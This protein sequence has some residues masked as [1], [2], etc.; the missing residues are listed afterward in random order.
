MQRIC[1]FVPRSLDL[2]TDTCFRQLAVVRG[3]VS[4]RSQEIGRNVNAIE[5]RCAPVSYGIVV[6]QRYDQKR[7][8]R[9]TV[10]RDKRDKKRWAI[11]QIE[12]L[13]QKV[14]LIGVECVS[15][16]LTTDQGETVTDEGVERRVNAKLSSA[17]LRKSYRAQFVMSTREPEDLPQ[18]MAER[19][20]VR[21]ICLVHISLEKVDK[22]LR[23]HHWW[24]FGER[25]ELAHFRLRL[26][27]GHADLRIQM[28]SGGSLVNNEADRIQVEWQASTRTHSLR[29]IDELDRPYV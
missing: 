2:L 26:I 9:Q 29:S 23:N 18:S 8:F 6:N 5:K 20:S 3:L 21:E 22:V 10:I 19:E 7:H 14:V 4:Y 11:D 28:M 25:Y 1:E 17:Q 24:N 13:I 12:W 16:L 27:P 15:D